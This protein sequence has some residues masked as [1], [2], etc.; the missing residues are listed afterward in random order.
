MNLT[1]IV[2]PTGI[3]IAL[4]ISEEDVALAFDEQPEPDVALFF[5]AFSKK[6]TALSASERVLVY[7]KILWLAEQ[8]VLATN[9]LNTTGQVEPKPTGE[10]R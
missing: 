1:G 4:E 7:S 2:T 9:K 3:S 5:K 6:H 8:A 10:L